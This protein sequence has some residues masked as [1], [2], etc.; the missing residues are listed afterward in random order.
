MLCRN[1]N[2]V[3]LILDLGSIATWRWIRT[4]PVPQKPIMIPQLGHFGDFRVVVFWIPA[5]KCK[6]NKRYAR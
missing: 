3:G 6:Y 1:L 4:D 5:S 2:V